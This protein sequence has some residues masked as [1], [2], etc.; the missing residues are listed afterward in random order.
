[1]ISFFILLLRTTI[2]KISEILYIKNTSQMFHKLIYTLPIPCAIVR[3]CKS[4]YI[5]ILLTVLKMKIW[6][7]WSEST[8]WIYFY[9]VLNKNWKIY[10]SEQSFTGLGPVLKVRTALIRV[11]LPHFCDCPKLEPGFTTS[12]VLSFQLVQSIWVTVVLL[13]L[14]E[15]MTITV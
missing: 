11:T 6:N 9:I 5:G 8:S 3:Y 7:Y 4:C 1:M 15:L 14:V 10:W 13:I 2:R 12:H